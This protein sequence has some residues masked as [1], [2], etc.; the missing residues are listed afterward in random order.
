MSDE[1]REKSSKEIS[2]PP[3][4]TPI[5]FREC[6]SCLEVLP[7]YRNFRAGK[8]GRRYEICNECY[9]ASQTDYWSTKKERTCKRCEQS[10]TIE[11]NFEKDSFG[12]PY[13]NCKFCREE[14]KGEWAAAAE[15][16]KRKKAQADK[17]KAAECVA[18]QKRTHDDANGGGDELS[19]DDSDGDGKPDEKD[20]V[21]RTK[22]VKSLGHVEKPTQSSP[23]NRSTASKKAK[24]GAMC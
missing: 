13:P 7:L 4:I 21:S 14:Q 6:R 8:D 16:R 2:S 9:Q 11:Q 10:R 12:N 20:V 19:G 18:S 17:A 3:A 22:N 24:K 5:K 1:E 15:E 23:A